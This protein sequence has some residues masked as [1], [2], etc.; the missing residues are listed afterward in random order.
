MG[1]DRVGLAQVEI[2]LAH[3]ASHGDAFGAGLARHRDQLMSAPAD[4]VR[5]GDRECN[6]LVDSGAQMSI[7]RREELKKLERNTYTLSRLDKPLVFSGIQEQYEL[8]NPIIAE[9]TLTYYHVHPKIEG[10]HSFVVCDELPVSIILGI[11]WV[12]K[13]GVDLLFSRKEMRL[14]RLGLTLPM[15]LTSGRRRKPAKGKYP[16]YS[17]HNAALPAYHQRILH[18]AVYDSIYKLLDTSEEI[19]GTHGIITEP[20]GSKG[21]AIGKGVGKI[22]NGEVRVLC[23]NL[24]PKS[25]WCQKINLSQCFTRST[26]TTSI[27]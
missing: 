2:D 24:S 12:V 17:T 10:K 15:M 8:N 14:N 5:I 3:R 18:C 16:L 9:I 4:N 21:I 13:E 6:L 22:Q 27:F 23:A 19:E 1:L 7:I 25:L 26:C 20:E 11:D